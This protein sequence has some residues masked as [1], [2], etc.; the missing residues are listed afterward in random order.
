MMKWTVI[1]FMLHSFIRGQEDGCCTPFP[2]DP[3][4]GCTFEDGTTVNL[5]SVGN[6]TGHPE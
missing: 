6:D 5:S 1:V 4:C 3:A 2:K